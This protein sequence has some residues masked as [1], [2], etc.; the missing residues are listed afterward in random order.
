L[1][2][3]GLWSASAKLADGGSISTGQVTLDKNGEATYKVGT[4][5]Y[6]AFFGVAP[7]K[8]LD[9]TLPVKAWATG[10]NMA[11][12]LTLDP[13][14]PGDTDAWVISPAAQAANIDIAATLPTIHASKDA[15]EASITIKIKVDSSLSE[16]TTINLG[17]LAATLTGK[18]GILWAD[19]ETWDLGT[20]N[21]KLPLPQTK[22]TVD[23]SS[24][25]T[26]AFT[27]YNYYANIMIDYGDGTPLTTARSHRY[28]DVLSQHTVT[29]YG[30]YDNPRFASNTTAVT[31]WD[32]A[33]EKTLTNLSN[34]FAMTTGG[35]LKSVVAPPS[36]N[37][38]N[39]E[40][41][42]MWQR[43]LTELKGK[44]DTSNVTN[45]AYVFANATAFSQDLSCW[46]ARNVTKYTGFANY[47][48][49]ANNTA[50]WPQFGQA[51]PAKCE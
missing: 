32:K 43:N 45:M 36:S 20:I 16:D 30:Y 6:D 49:F 46:D 22:F 15:Q 31:R 8:T 9:I 38:T 24:D 18:P 17:A 13:D 21:A 41:M 35:V 37:V 1:G 39:M 11:P 40:S 2:A 44:W 19:T 5:A 7:G 42:F 33:L 29:V 50:L 25:K 3:N 27:P 12:E 48:G 26:A 34:T 4:A 51:P 23:T 47:A 10:T 28:T 14:G